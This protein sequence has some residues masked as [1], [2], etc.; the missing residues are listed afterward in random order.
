MWGCGCD[1]CDGDDDGDGFGRQRG[2]VNGGSDGGGGNGGGG[3]VVVV[4]GVVTVAVG[5][6]LT[7]KNRTIILPSTRR[8][9]ISKC[10]FE[11]VVK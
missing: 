1:N 10:I 6:A 8:S 11:T 4:W 9:R 7:S 5:V 2:G 3:S